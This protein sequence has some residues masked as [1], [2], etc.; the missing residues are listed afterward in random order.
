M[1]ITTIKRLDLEEDSLIISKIFPIIVIVVRPRL[2]DSI[3]CHLVK[4]FHILQIFEN[5][6][7]TKYDAICEFLLLFYL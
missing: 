2:V 1:L 7:W 4:A 5:I 3:K 6:S